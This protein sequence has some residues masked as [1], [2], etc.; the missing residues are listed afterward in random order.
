MRFHA[1]GRAF[2]G[3]RTRLANR[4]TCLIAFSPSSDGPRSA[5]AELVSVNAN[6]RPVAFRADYYAI[7]D[8]VQG[9][10]AIQSRGPVDKDLHGP[11]HRQ[12]M[13]GGEQNAAAADVHCLPR[14]DGHPVPAQELVLKIL[15]ERKPA[16]SPALRWTSGG[17]Y[18]MWALPR[19]ISTSWRNLGERTIETLDGIAPLS[20]GILRRTV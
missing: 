12:A 10:R 1:G 20:F 7:Y 14:A 19:S 2:A 11:A 6:R 4:T 9:A 3:Q 15:A 5:S 18:I 16:G 17:S 13:F 8:E